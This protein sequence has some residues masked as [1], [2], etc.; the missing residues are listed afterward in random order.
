MRTLV[1]RRRPT[2]PGT[3]PASTSTSGSPPR[4]AIAP[5]AP[6]RSPRRRAS[7]SR[8]RSSGSRTARSRPTSSRCVREGDAFELRGPIG[9]YFVW[10]PADGGPLLLV[11]GGSGVVPLRAMLRHRRRSGSDVPTRLLYSSRTLDD[12]IYRDELDRARRGARGSPDADAR[13]AAGLDRL[14]AAGSTSE[15]LREVAW[16]AERGPAGVRLRPDEL[17]RGG[18]ERRSSSSATT[19]RRVKTERFG[20]TGGR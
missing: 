8:S 3:A 16:P 2:G 14:R 15:L 6:T 10:D 13:A 11:A 4:T 7:R 19:R 20:A 17:R 9:G 1:A 12:V 5:S 18:R